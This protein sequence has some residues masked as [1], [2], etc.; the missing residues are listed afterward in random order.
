MCLRGIDVHRGVK[1]GDG[2]S[3]KYR[4]NRMYGKRR[5]EGWCSEGV[6]V[7]VWW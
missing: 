3:T 6:R 4:V 5:D 7:T 1:G 2:G